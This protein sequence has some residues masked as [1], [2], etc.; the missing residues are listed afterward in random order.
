MPDDH[1]VSQ[2]AGI[3]LIFTFK[4]ARVIDAI[5]DVVGVQ[6]EISEL[7]REARESDDKDTNKEEIEELMKE[8]LP[9]E[10]EDAQNAFASLHNGSVIWTVLS[11]FGGAIFGLGIISIFPMENENERIRSTALLLMTNTGGLVGGAAL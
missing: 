9:A 5:G 7:R 11:Q 10:Q 2:L 4:Q 6:A 3:S 1:R 8:D